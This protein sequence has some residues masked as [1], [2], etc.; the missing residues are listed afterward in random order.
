MQAIR[1]GVRRIEIC[2]R[3]RVAINYPL[4]S[5]TCHQSR[6]TAIPNMGLRNVSRGTSRPN[7][8]PL[9]FKNGATT[10][11]RNSSLARLSRIRAS[12]HHTQHEI[13]C[14]ALVT[15]LGSQ[16]LLVIELYNRST[17]T[18]S[19]WPYGWC[20][21]SIQWWVKDLRETLPRHTGGH[22]MPW[23]SSAKKQTYHQMK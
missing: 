1:R 7:W 8:A 15:P 11:P 2:Q 21:W 16:L 13:K 3:W 22:A 23:L 12:L 9:R 14:V 17:A 20:W 19:L 18:I 5:S 10:E 4:P 6:R